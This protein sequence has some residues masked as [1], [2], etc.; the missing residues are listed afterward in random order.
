M[1]YAR[2]PLW[3]ENSWEELCRPGLIPIFKFIFWNKFNYFV[4]SVFI[5]FE[6]LVTFNAVLR[7]FL[8]FRVTEREFLGKI[9]LGK[10]IRR[11]E[12]DTIA[13]K[14]FRVRW[15]VKR[16]LYCVIA[17]AVRFYKSNR[18]CQNIVKCDQNTIL[19]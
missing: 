3:W 8:L 15:T 11:I 2:F 10:G 4:P 16:A 9:T 13:A 14:H 1:I 17:K 12:L 19:I 6:R 18:Y 5:S 7:V